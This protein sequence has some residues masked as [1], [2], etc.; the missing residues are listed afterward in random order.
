MRN[1]AE[2]TDEE[3]ETVQ[4]EHLILGRHSC[5]VGSGSSFDELRVL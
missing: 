1:E 5:S 4:T 2:I 3:R